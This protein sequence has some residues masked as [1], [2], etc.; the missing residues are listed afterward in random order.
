M[1][2]YQTIYDLLNQYVFANGLVVG[3]VQELAVVLASLVGTL[4][5]V[6]LPFLIVWK[7]LKL[8]GGI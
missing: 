6:A 3:S 5:L 1:N 8:L 4:F 7:V 2:I